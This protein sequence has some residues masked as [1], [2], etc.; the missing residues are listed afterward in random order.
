[1]KHILEVL[2]AYIE[3]KVNELEFKQERIDEQWL[4]IRKLNEENQALRND[5]AKLRKQFKSK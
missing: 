4:E 3:Q 2:N 5:L 1:M